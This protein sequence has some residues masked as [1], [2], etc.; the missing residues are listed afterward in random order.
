[1]SASSIIY[2]IFVEKCCKDGLLLNGNFQ[3]IV[4]KSTN[5]LIEENTHENNDFI[6]YR[7]LKF[8]KMQID[9]HKKTN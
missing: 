3:I 7:V 1:M 9:A 2:W 5:I 4:F 8:N 6:E